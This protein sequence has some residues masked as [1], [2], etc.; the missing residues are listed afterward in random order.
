MPPGEGAYNNMF[1]CKAKVS[2]FTDCKFRQPYS[3]GA[4][5][6]SQLFL[7]SFP[8]LRREPG[9][10]LSFFKLKSSIN[11]WAFLN[12]KQSILLNYEYVCM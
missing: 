2:L 7:A 9:N 3:K 11:L 5:Y 4:L 12:S 1:H 6:H 10:E 8:F